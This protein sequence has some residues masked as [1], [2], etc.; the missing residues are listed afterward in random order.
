MPKL[1][2][3][4]GEQV[5]AILE[6]FGFVVVRVAGSHHILQRE[7]EGKH[8][9]LNV[10]VHGRKSLGKGMLRRLYRDACQFISEDDLRSRFYT[11]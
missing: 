5:V 2:N 11:D 3:L 1:R 10:P 9:T 4:T 6:L 7:H 8:Q